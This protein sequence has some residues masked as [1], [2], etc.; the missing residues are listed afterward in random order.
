MVAGR[1]GSSGTSSWLPVPCTCTRP[2]RRVPA[3][4]ERPRLVRALPGFGSLLEAGLRRAGMIPRELADERSGRDPKVRRLVESVADIG[5][6]CSRLTSKGRGC[7]SLAA[8]RRSCS[9][10]RATHPEN[11]RQYREDEH[12]QTHWAPLSA[13][14]SAL[15]CVAY[16]HATAG[17][18][19]AGVA[20]KNSRDRGLPRRPRSQGLVG[21]MGS[22][23][24][25]ERAR[26]KSSARR[27]Q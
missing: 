21:A 5:R 7:E 16:H 20:R 12:P 3:D 24:K 27:P 11:Q 17:S 18:T 15:H 2:P 8:R 9:R 1:F 19:Q 13:E 25:A 6:A 26:M 10:G 22:G 23:G 14:F 4:S